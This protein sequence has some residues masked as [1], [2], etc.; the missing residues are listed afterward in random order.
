M[1]TATNKNVFC[2]RFTSLPLQLIC[3]IFN[4]DS[5]TSIG[6]AVDFAFSCHTFNVYFPGGTSFKRNFPS[7]SVRA[8]YGVSVTM[9]YADISACTLQSIGQIPG[10]SK[11]WYFVC[12]CG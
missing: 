12:F 5:P 1:L 11:I 6:R 2:L 8:K 7:L 4:F 3:G 10:L 9:T